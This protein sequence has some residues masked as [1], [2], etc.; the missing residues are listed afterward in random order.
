MKDLKAKFIRKLPIKY[1]GR[2]IVEV[3]YTRKDGFTKKQIEQQATKIRNRYAEKMT[4][5]LMIGEKYR[6]GWRSG[7]A[8]ALDKDTPVN[9][10]DISD[11][12]NEDNLP[13]DIQKS[14][15]NQNKFNAFSVYIIPTGQ[16][17]GGCDGEWNDCLWKCLRTAYNGAEY[18]PK[19]IEKPTQL[20]TMVGVKKADKIPVDKLGIIE[21]KLRIRINVSGD[22][23]R[24]ST[25][26]Y[27]R[28]VDLILS[29]EHYTL[30]PM[31]NRSLLKGWTKNKQRKLLVWEKRDGNE[32]VCYDGESERPL[33]REEFIELKNKPYSS[34]HVL[35]P[36]NR[37]KS[38]QETYDDWFEVRNDLYTQTDGLINMQNFGKIKFAALWLFHNK[39]RSLR[40]PDPI[41]QD[42][43]EWIMNASMG[44]L[45]W[46][47]KE[48]ELEHGVDYDFT[49]MYPAIMAS[50]M[51]RFPVK[52]GIFTQLDEIPETKVPYGIYRCIIHRAEKA[53]QVNRFFKFNP[54]N[55]YTHTDIMAAQRLGLSVELMD[56]ECNALLYPSDRTVKGSIMFKP[57]V[58]YV[59]ALKE[60]K[61]KG[62]KQL[63][64]ILWGALCE[65]RTYMRDT[66]RGEVEIKDADITS[67]EPRGEKETDAVWV[68]FQKRD[69]CFA[70]D[71]ARI[72]PF[73][74]AYGRNTLSN[75]VSSHP[76]Q[77]KAF[78]TDGFVTDGELQMSK[79][80]EKAGLGSL[81]VK[82]SGP[83]FI[84]NACSIQ[85]NIE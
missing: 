4:G 23:L 19:K 61:V 18:L 63:I 20:K 69:Q 5:K 31:K 70:T 47:E 21:D 62:A 12:Y 42:E 45:I 15:L 79:P 1:G 54:S 2:N 76:Q 64:N 9:L 48:T 75:V 56:L 65:K 71:Y 7:K 78:H 36:S 40:Q 49:S 10:Y 28:E 30:K 80:L 38:M 83:C 55:Y 33:P 81:R 43:A 68:E 25:A 16:A 34:D 50:Q 53:R 77:V 41:E 11:Y 67:I 85:W 14:D 66:S 26:S 51:K 59:F 24:S 57:F 27:E 22:Y 44:G 29:N 39:S 35:I 84:K 6:Y 58:D 17:A 3:R 74:T 82:H 60:K 73:I 52:R 8:T 37:G 72:A 32:L 13:D 46:A